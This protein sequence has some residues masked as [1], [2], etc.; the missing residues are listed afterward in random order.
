MKLSIMEATLE[1]G[2]HDKS[3]SKV[4]GL[5]LSKCTDLTG[6]DWVWVLWTFFFR[7]LLGRSFRAGSWSWL[8]LFA[9]PFTL[10]L[11]LSSPAFLALALSLFWSVCIWSQSCCCCCWL[12]LFTWLLLFLFWLEFS[13]LGEQEAATRVEHGEELVGDGDNWLKTKQ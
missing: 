3:S 11:S 1:A 8:P 13:G 7:R 6:P 5:R 9:L 4:W 10:P 2:E 12:E